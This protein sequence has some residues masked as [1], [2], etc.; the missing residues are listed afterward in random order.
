[1]G[2]EELKLKILNGSAKLIARQNN[3]DKNDINLL[4]EGV[5]EHMLDSGT[6]LLHFENLYVQINFEEASILSFLIDDGEG[7]V[8]DLER[9]TRVFDTRLNVNRKEGLKRL[10]ADLSINDSETNYL[11]R[12]VFSKS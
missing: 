8:L 2:R 9:Y 7:R 6:E 3:A 4:V 5:M 12:M 11:S 10:M 1:M